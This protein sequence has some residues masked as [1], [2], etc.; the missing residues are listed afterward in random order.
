MGASR[1]AAS[2]AAP[3]RTIAGIAA[4][5]LVAAFLA[6]PGLAS[7]QK[8]RR[9]GTATVVSV[10]GPALLTIKTTK[11]QK[12]RM[13]L[14]GVDAP[15]PGECGATES[16]AALAKLTKGDRGTLR[17][18]LVERRSGVYERSSDGSLLG[19]LGPINRGL[20]VFFYGL[21]GELL[22]T[23]WARSGDTLRPDQAPIAH[24]ETMAGYSEEPTGPRPA[25]GLWA[26]CG[27]R[28]HL[29]GGEAPPA[30]QPAPWTITSNGI[31]TAIGPLLLPATLAP[32]ATL[33]VAAV[34]AIAPV[35]L[36]DFGDTCQARVP[37]LEIVLVAATPT[38]EQPCSRAEVHAIATDGPG[39]ATTTTTGLAI[40]E[41]ADLLPK[42]FPRV[43]GLDGSVCDEDVL[44]LAGPQLRPWAWQ[45]EAEVHYESCVVIGLSTSTAPRGG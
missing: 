4:F 32:G 18:S 14:F 16:A 9:S 24:G 33:T 11:G 15:A 37:S 29:P 2:P 28:V 13:R 7:A 44:A 30:H 21:S 3:R 19:S 45:T 41:R 39:S 23:E 31:T 42:L 35:E 34:A 43:G 27:G 1:H 36:D 22:A 25:R 38:A 17:Y 26:A 40:G 10:D 5:T 8:L 6:A 20:D 12:L